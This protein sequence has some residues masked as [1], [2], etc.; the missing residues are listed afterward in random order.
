MRIVID[1][2]LEDV[3]DNRF[4][5]RAEYGDVGEL[6]ADI[7]ARGLLH[8]PIGR[9]VRAT[10]GLPLDA[11]QTEDAV[12][13]IQFQGWSGGMRVELAFGHRRVRAV[14]LIAG[15]ETVPV[16]IAVLSDEQMLDL[17]WS[18]N[19]RRRDVNP[20]EQ[21]E[22][23]AAKVARARERGGG[24][25]SV[26]EEWGLD[27]STVAN[28][29]RLLKLPPAAQAAVR[30]G[31][32][33]ER[34]ALALLAVVKGGGEDVA[35]EV[36]AGGESSDEIRRRAGSSAGRGAG[37]PA[38]ALQGKQVPMLKF[39]GARG[40]DG[41]TRGQV[42]AAARA[43]CERCVAVAGPPSERVCR[44]CPG[45]MLVERLTKRAGGGPA[46]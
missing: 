27:R 30:A 36:L 41:F 19:E 31:Q 21:A 17:L 20:M 13:N 38:A 35:A 23:L 24:Q 1:V 16:C 43:A 44:E 8:P 37:R 33:S 9:L 5:T 2:P 42:E 32:M 10:S 14:R 18:E 12:R 34:Q 7:R 26:A 15:A 39:V 4:Q 6:A 46:I 11:G 29:I 28:K 3:V 40:P 45:V 25:Q 22:L